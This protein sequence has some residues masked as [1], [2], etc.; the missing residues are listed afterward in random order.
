[1]KELETETAKY[2]QFLQVRKTSLFCE[3]QI[4]Y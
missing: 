2:C 3:I 1:M 4:V